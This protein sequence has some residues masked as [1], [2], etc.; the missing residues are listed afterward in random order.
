MH[1]F[2]LMHVLLLG[3]AIFVLAKFGWKPFAILLVVGFLYV[4]GVIAYLFAH[5]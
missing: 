3:A 2:T 4:M 5:F 1:T